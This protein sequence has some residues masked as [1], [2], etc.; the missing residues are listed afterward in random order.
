MAKD[1][2]KKR[3]KGG[4]NRGKRCKGDGEERQFEKVEI[5]QQIEE[6]REDFL[7]RHKGKRKRNEIMRLEYWISWYESVIAKYEENGLAAWSA[8]DGLKRVRKE[9]QKLRDEEK[10]SDKD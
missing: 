6:D 3:M 8:R 1:T 7:T 10:K 5:E 2:Y 4:W 9:L